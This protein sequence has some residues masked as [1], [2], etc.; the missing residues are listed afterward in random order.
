MLDQE[1]VMASQDSS[2]LLLM[3]GWPLLDLASVTELTVQCVKYER[4]LYLTDSSV[5]LI[6]SELYS[7]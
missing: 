7:S 4:H 3:L 1:E 6:A 5:P 2:Q